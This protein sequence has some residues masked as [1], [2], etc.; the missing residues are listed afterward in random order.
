MK[1]MNGIWLSEILL[2]ASFGTGGSWDLQKFE[3][4]FCEWGGVQWGHRSVKLTVGPSSVLFNQCSMLLGVGIHQLQ[5]V[6]IYLT[7]GAK[8]PDNRVLPVGPCWVTWVP[9]IPHVHPT[10]NYATDSSLEGPG[11]G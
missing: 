5:T 4:F 1:L 8:A 10:S 3:G 2:P 7:S 9:H 11:P 6:Y